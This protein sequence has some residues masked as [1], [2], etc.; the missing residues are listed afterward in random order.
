MLAGLIASLS[1]VLARALGITSLNLEMFIGSLITRSTGPLTWFYG[2]GVYLLCSG[3]LGILYKQ[4][5]ILATRLGS[6]RSSWDLGA[7]FG[8]AHWLIASLLLGKLSVIH[9]LSHGEIQL[10]GPFALNLG[11]L[12]FVNFFLIHLI[13]GAIMGALMGLILS[14]S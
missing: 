12:S 4:G 8:I 7:T 6:S 3:L 1:L 13:F 9:P 10:P 5:F 11:G 2:L 14:E